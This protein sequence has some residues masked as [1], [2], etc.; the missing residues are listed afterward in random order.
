MN[1]R[2]LTVPANHPMQ[3]ALVTNEDIVESAVGM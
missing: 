1:K 3:A 2:Q